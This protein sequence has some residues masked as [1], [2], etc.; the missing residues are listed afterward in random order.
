MELFRRLFHA[1]RIGMRQPRRRVM[2]VML[3]VL[4]VIAL[5][6]VIEA[7]W[8]W[9]EALTPAGNRFGRGL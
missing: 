9:P 6:L 7:I 4:V 3:I 2:L 8:G 5:L 1:F